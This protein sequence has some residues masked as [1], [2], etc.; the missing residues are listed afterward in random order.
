MSGG[1]PDNRGPVL[2]LVFLVMAALI[3][4]AWGLGRDPEPRDGAPL[5]PGGAGTSVVGSAGTSLDRASP[6]LR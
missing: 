3:A 5:G 1:P 2:F 6:S 4:V